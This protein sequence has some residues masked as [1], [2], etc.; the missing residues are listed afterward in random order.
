MKVKIVKASN[1]DY[2]YADKIGHCYIVYAV[3]LIGYYVGGSLPYILKEDCEIVKEPVTKP[4]LG[5]R[6]E[7]VVLEHRQ[8]E[9]QEAVTRYMEAGVDIPKE[10]TTEYYRNNSR[11]LEIKNGN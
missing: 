10:W 6:P 7:F 8:K 11:L 2:W 5:L 4:P 9:I 1:S 3:G